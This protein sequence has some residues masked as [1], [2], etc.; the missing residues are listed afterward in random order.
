M[1]ETPKHQGQMSKLIGIIDDNEAM[2]DSLRDLIESAGFEVRCFGSGGAF[3]D[4]DLQGQAACLIVDIRMPKMTGLELQARLKEVACSI[5]I[6]FVTAYEDAALRT[7]A[8][9]A[10]AVAFVVKPFDH[11][12]LLSMLRSA[13]ER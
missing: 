10:G 11:R 4:S 1:G 8:M 6:I 2:R 7:Q 13:L 9:N 5:P 12:L 3:L